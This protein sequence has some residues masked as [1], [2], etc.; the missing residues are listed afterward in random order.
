MFDND[1]T[2]EHGMREVNGN[3]RDGM[4][5]MCDAIDNGG[6][7]C[8]TNGN[9]DAKR[10]ITVAHICPEYLNL[11]GD[12]GNILVLRK[13][14]EWRGI[15]FSV[16]EFKLGDDVDLDRIDIVVI[17]GGFSGGGSGGGGGGSW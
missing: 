3:M 11:Y 10:R 14:C 7:T 1:K 13:R 2:K 17:G 12:S 4:N 15:K 9:G 16:R 8:A 6:K 5:D